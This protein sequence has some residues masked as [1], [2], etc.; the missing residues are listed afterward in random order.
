[1]EDWISHHD[2]GERG[3]E[4]E[5]IELSEYSGRVAS[6]GRDITASVIDQFLELQLCLANEYSDNMLGMVYRC[7][8]HSAVQ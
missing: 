7:E 3:K 2:R 6:S 1:M 4:G 8:A 5:A